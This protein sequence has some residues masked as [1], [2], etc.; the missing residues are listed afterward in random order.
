M[1]C[2]GVVWCGVVWCGVVWC[3]IAHKITLTL[4][5]DQIAMLV[6]KTAGPDVLG[7]LT[8]V[9]ATHDQRIVQVEKVL[10]YHYGIRYVIW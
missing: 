7:Q 9:A 4:K 6:G 1:L 10:A 8:Y 5:Q 2:C 3:V